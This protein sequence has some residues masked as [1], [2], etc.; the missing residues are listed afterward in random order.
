[1]LLRDDIL[2]DIWCAVRSRG[3]ASP[4]GHLFFSLK[5][6]DALIKGVVW[7]PL[8]YRL[9]SQLTD[10]QEVLVHGRVDLYPQQGVYQLYVDEAMPVGTGIAYLEFERVRAKLEAEGL[11][12]QERKRPLPAFP[13]ESG[14]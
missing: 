8:S 6:S 5:D 2:Q 12:D 1:M 14:W 10:G 7:A 9:R 13:A 3:R 4:G 11:F